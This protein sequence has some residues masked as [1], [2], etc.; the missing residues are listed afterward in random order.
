MQPTP[1]G[2]VDQLVEL[3]REMQANNAEITAGSIVSVQGLPIA[4]QLPR[5]SN[6]GIV[7]AMAAA[8]LSVSMRACEELQRGTMRRLI[9]E[10]DAGVFVCQ[11]A[12]E[13]AIL[14]IL[15]TAEAKMGM[16]HLDMAKACKNIEKILG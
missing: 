14:T 5:T 16:L 7:S 4:S 11:Y 1:Q 12:G 3:L 13:H 10:G 8:L 6:E 15:A 9:V 2:S